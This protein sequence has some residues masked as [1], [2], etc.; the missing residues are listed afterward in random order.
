MKNCHTCRHNS[1]EYVEPTPSRVV[2]NECR[3]PAVGD[4]FP[5]D[6]QNWIEEQRL[7]HAGMPAEDADGCPGYDPIF[8]PQASWSTDRMDGSG[9]ATNPSGIAADPSAT[10]HHVYIPWGDTLIKGKP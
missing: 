4:L 7:D 6:I 10:V 1:Q 9:N 8:A 5:D 2:Y 3:P